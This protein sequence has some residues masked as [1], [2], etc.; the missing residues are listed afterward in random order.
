MAKRHNQKK[1]SF[2]ELRFNHKPLVYVAIE[3]FTTIFHLRRHFDFVIVFRKQNYI[4]HN[5]VY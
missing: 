5:T 3:G 4:G 2:Y 1:G